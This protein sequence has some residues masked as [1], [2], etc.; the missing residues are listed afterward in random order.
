M[1]PRPSPILPAAGLLLG[2]LLLSAC[3]K[4]D[5]GNGGRAMP[6]VAVTTQVVGMEP[7]TDTITAL[8]TVRAR[9]AVTV[10]A[11]VS[12]TVEEI[13]FESGDEVAAGAVLV[14]LSGKQQQAALEAAEA[15][16]LEAE[17]QYRRGLELARQQLIARS[18]LDTQR[19][20]RD[21]ALARVEQLRA[22]IGD[23]R[24][25]APFAGVLGI[26]QVSPGALVT[27]G[28]PIATLD[29]ISSVYVDFPVPET[30]LAGL[31]P[32]LLL[33]GRAGAYPGRVFEGTVAAVAARL[34]EVTRAATVRGEF[35]NP[36]RVLRPGMLMEVEVARATRPELV[37][38][39]IA[40]QQVGSETFVWRVAG[41]VVEKAPIQ[42]GGRVP[43]RVMVAGGLAEGDRIVVEGTGKLQ[44][45]A[46]IRD[47]SDSGSGGADAAA[48][49]AGQ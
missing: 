34:D 6:A 46:K 20:T 5:A 11:K 18:Q 10:T 48:S 44:A 3:G 39:E 12:E 33:R 49:G 26:R 7:W 21:A 2:C 17:Q 35:P 28:T 16:A 8:G 25:R 23:R 4:D 22:D 43:G 38:P 42:V 24:I 32:R 19:A 47:V 15:A 27:P 29:D 41:D 9:E 30:R 1:N 36:D 37:V 14:T 31:E 13:H 45:G 40:V